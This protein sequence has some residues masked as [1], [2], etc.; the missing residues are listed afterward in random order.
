MRSV[1]RSS[2]ALPVAALLFFALPLPAAASADDAEA[3]VR[4]T[5]FEGVPPDRAQALG[6]AGGERLAEMLADPD[7]AKHHKNIVVTL[8]LCGCGP[9]FETLVA[10]DAVVR[11]GDLELDAFLAWEQVPY[12]MGHLGR[13]DARAIDWLTA[14]AGDTEA[15]PT[16]SHGHRS[17][18]TLARQRRLAAIQ[19]LGLTGTV[20]A[21]DALS[22]LAASESD[23]RF[24]RKIQQAHNICARV[25]EHGLAGLQR[26]GAQ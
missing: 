12:A 26:R 3:L 21:D 19:G 8:G 1:V 17:A 15:R 4:E 23:A 11:S 10:F 22:A 14:T 25:G 6:A 13:S 5:Y 2:L 9:A 24:Q 7:E 18:D 20:R 16:F